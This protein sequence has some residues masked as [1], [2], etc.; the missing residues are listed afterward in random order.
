MDRNLDIDWELKMKHDTTEIL[1][2]SLHI[3]IIPS[4]SDAW[5]QLSLCCSSCA[6]IIWLNITSWRVS[7]TETVLVIKWFSLVR[8]WTRA[9]LNDKTKR[10]SSFRFRTRAFRFLDRMIDSEGDGKW[11][12]YEEWDDENLRNSDRRRHRCH[13]WNLL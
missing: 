5:C 4:L 11:A 3:S 1:S 2:N 12:G 13:K 10:T 9:A 8:K 6:Y 7:I